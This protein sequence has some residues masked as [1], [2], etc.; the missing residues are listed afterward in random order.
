MTKMLQELN[1]QPLQQCRKELWLTFLFE[2]AEELVPAIPLDMFLTPQR[3][4][5]RI[6]ARAI[7][8]CVSINLV[9]KYKTNNSKCYI[10]P[11]SSTEVYNHF[12]L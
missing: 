11:K 1:I 8:D 12:F 4:K 6:T 10:I 2:I 9:T 5:L 3:N 7:N